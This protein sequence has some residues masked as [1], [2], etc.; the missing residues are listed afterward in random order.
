MHDPRIACLPV[1]ISNPKRL[2][3]DL[4][5][6]AARPEKHEPHTGDSRERNHEY[7][8]HELEKKRRTKLD[9]VMNNEDRNTKRMVKMK[10]NM[11]VSDVDEI[12][13]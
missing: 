12:Y 8:D 5:R 10:D 4:G 2:A 6:P 13:K 9:H 1:C 11:E 3:R 7:N